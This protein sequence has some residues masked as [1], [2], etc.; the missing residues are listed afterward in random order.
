MGA[1]DPPST[2]L[3]DHDSHAVLPMI[4]RLQFG[5]LTRGVDAGG[6]EVLTSLKMC[7]NGPS[8]F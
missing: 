8:M 4:D 6:G 1:G 3:I 2:I 7:R 5:W